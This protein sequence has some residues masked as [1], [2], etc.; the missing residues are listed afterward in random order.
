MPWLTGTAQW[1]FKDFSTPLRPENP[2]PRMNQKGLV[3][4]DLTPKESYY[5]FQSYWSEK[6]MAHIYGHSWPMRW[7]NEGEAKVVKVYSNCPQ[8]ELFVN[9]VSCGTKTRN[10]Q[11]F[12]AAGLRWMVKL[13]EG[14]NRI[15]VI[16]RKGSV[17]V[18]DEITTFYQTRKFGKPTHFELSQTKL[19]NGA[20]QVEAWLM[21]SNGILCVE[22]RNPVR[23]GL[24]G[25][26]ELLDNLGTVRGSRKVE[27]CNGRAWITVQPRGGKSVVS[28]SSPGLPTA[29]ITLS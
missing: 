23:F 11:D 15:K 4:R 27:L 28:I 29:L 19:A 10:S 2:V 24:A 14:N 7:G 5:L 8:A 21:D 26:G 17:E 20:I 12:P 18:T 13:E 25:D 3:E 22:A 1:I 6:P 16:A 9:G